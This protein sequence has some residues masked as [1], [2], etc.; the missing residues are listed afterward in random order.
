M[1]VENPKIFRQAFRFSEKQPYRGAA[2]PPMP[3][4]GIAS[5][6]GRAESKLIEQYYHIAGL[7]AAFLFVTFTINQ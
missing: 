5:V 1:T 7:T 3:P 4:I 2:H 6:A